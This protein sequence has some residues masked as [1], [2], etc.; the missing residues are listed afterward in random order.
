MLSISRRTLLHFAP[1]SANKIETRPS[2]TNVYASKSKPLTLEIPN[3]EDVRKSYKSILETVSKNKYNVMSSMLL[4]YVSNF[5]VQ[6]R[7]VDRE[8]EMSALVLFAVFLLA[9]S[10]LKF[11][12]ITSPPRNPRIVCSDQKFKEIV[13]KY[14]PA[15]LET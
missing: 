3:W 13:L 12:N 11:L 7:S 10:I 14:C 8:G 5:F 9:F 15:L 4:T 1:V 2:F 6:Y